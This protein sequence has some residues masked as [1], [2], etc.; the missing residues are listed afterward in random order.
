M[1]STV[2]LIIYNITFLFFLCLLFVN[3]LINI[4]F[5]IINWFDFII[6]IVIILFWTFYFIFLFYWFICLSID[7]FV[8]LFKW[9]TSID[10]LILSFLPFIYCCSNV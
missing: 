4:L 9:N 6:V 1:F 2:I 8:K 5:F 3:L 7:L 10:L